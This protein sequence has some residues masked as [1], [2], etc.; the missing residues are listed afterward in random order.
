ME[1]IYDDLDNYF[2]SNEFN[3][4]TS[5]ILVLMENVNKWITNSIPGAIIYG[6][7]RIGKTRAILYISDELKKKYGAELPIF[8]HNA[9]EH[10]PKD[11]FFYSEML[12]TVNHPDFDK[13]TVSMLKERLINSLIRY[14]GCTKSKKIVLFIDEAYNFTDKDFKWLMDV[15]NN[16]YL[17]D[18]HLTVFLVGSEELISKKQAL[19]M[20]RQSQIV[21]R[22]MVSQCQF[23]GIKT[24]NDISI[25]LYNFD[26]ECLINNKN[27]VLTECY[28]PDAYKDGKELSDCAEDLWQAFCEIKKDNGILDEADIPMMYLINTIRYCL[29]TYG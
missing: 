23:Y 9:T 4:M 19:I 13:G 24:L 6:R 3:I 22:F 16:L 15:Y 10:I 25:C 21:G 5:Q 11:K 20:T 1:N 8:I 29:S 18:I 27:I 26:Q 17:K 14:A 12:K 28:F 2:V 7:P